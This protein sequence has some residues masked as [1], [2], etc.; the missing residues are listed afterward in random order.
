MEN[1]SMATGK[2]SMADLS[3]AERREALALERATNTLAVKIG[4]VL[5]F[6]FLLMIVLAMSVIIVGGAVLIWRAL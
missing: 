4:A 6:L 3:P 1:G 2:V 5:G